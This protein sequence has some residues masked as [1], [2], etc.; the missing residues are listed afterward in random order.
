M[1]KPPN[2][3]PGRYVV[4]ALFAL[5]YFV[6]FPQDWS[7]IFSLVE[8]ALAI[9][10]AVSPWLYALLAVGLVCWTMVRIWGSKGSGSASA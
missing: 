3:L 4:L 7:A 1:A 6:I 8:R 9:S 10:N 2:R 5:V